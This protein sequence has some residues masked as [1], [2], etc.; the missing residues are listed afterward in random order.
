MRLVLEFTLKDQNMPLEYRKVFMH[1][2]KSCLTNANEGKYYDSFYEEAKSK[3]FTFSMFFDN[4]QYTKEKVILSSKRV[5][6][7]FSVLDKM[8]GYIFYSGFLEKKNTKV[9][10]EDDNFMILNKVTKISEP[11]VHN[12]KMLIKMNSPLLARKHNRES[13]RDEYFYYEQEEFIQ[14][15]EYNLRL[16]LTRQGFQDVLISGLMVIPVKCRKVVVTHYG[17][18][19]AGSLGNFLIEGDAVILNYLLKSGFGSRHSEGFGMA[20]FL[21]D[22]L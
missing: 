6:V 16:Q 17:C 3:N 13:N 10:L 18:K 21:T 4:P 19:F 8:E 14:E 1:F 2:I 22:D 20:E 7:I 9:L 12:N 5:K 11:E 15:L